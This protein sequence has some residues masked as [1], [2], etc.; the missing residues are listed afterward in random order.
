MPVEKSKERMY[1]CFEWQG[2]VGRVPKPAGVN[3]MTHIRMA[4][5]EHQDLTCLALNFLWSTLTAFLL[6]L[7][8]KE[9]AASCHSILRM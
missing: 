3:A 5:T 4:A 7:F 1:V 6:L 2:H 8:G 9:G